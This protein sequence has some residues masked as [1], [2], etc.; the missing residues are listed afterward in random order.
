MSF[1]SL[2]CSSV[3]RVNKGSHG[4]TCHLCIYPQLE[5]AVPAF[6]SSRRILQPSGQHW[7]PIPLRIGGWVGRAGWSHTE[8]VYPLNKVDTHINTNWAGCEVTALI[9]PNAVISMPSRHNYV[10]FSTFTTV[11]LCWLPSVLV[12]CCFDNSKGVW[13]MKT[14]AKKIP[15]LCCWDTW[16]NLEYF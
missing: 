6:T 15:E 12:F 5:W 10:V 3:A 16:S 8:T 2:R 9:L 1:S 4:Y 7:F 14:L 11:Y 13:P